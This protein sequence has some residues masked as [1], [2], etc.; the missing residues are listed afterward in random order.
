MGRTK[1]YKIS[2]VIGETEKELRVRVAEAVNAHPGSLDDKA[3]S[4]QPNDIE[5]IRAIGGP[6]VAQ[7]EE[8]H[9]RSSVK[10][11]EAAEDKLSH[12]KVRK[13][14]ESE[15]RPKELLKNLR[16][17]REKHWS[18]DT[19]SQIGRESRVDLSPESTWTKV[20]ANLNRSASAEG[21]DRAQAG[22]RGR[23]FS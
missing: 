18:S 19:A 5:Y 22:L 21:L 3:V 2:R 10:L 8:T 15:L 7:V 6:I 14:A 9:R 13:E 1:E 11:Y 20:T 4:I 23:S 12:K 16:S 17:G